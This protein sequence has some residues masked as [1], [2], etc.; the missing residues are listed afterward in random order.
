MTVDSSM[1][2]VRIFTDGSCRGN[3][4]PG[5]WAALLRY[6]DAEKELAGFEDHTTNNRMELRAVVEALRALKEP[7]RVSLCTDSMYLRDGIT[8]WI[9]NWKR[10]GWKT[11]A[12]E[13]VKNRDLW[14]ALD[15]AA[16][17]HQVDW[18]WV[19]GHAG[20][21]ENERCDRLAKE[22]IDKRGR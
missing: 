22:Q 15:E 16:Q 4:G 10:N 18:K 7:C 20:H 8:K 19:R 13:P 3:P 1:K 12:K 21:P 5:G 6:K 2:S 9:H 11:S 14:V 17:R